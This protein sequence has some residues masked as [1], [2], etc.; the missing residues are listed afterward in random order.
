[1]KKLLLALCLASGCATAQQSGTIAADGLLAVSQAAR[2]VAKSLPASARTPTV[3][4]DLQHFAA[5]MQAAAA[6]V[7]PTCAATAPAML[8][9]AQQAVSDAFAAL[10]RDLAA[11]PPHT[12][13]LST[14]DALAI[15]AAVIGGL[16]AL[17]P[18]GIAIYNAVHAPP[19]QDACAAAAKALQDDV[20]TLPAA[21]AAP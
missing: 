13:A 20:A 6:L 21:L 8:Q 16:S 4:A 1:M 5:A 11:P 18:G 14:T 9:A 2:A 7:P 15:T 17:I 19:S 12:A 3:T 10:L